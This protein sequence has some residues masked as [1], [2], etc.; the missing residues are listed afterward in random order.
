MDNHQKSE[1]LFEL[2]AVLGRQNEFNE[3]LRI[4]STKASALVD[5]DVATILMLNPHTQD[6]IKTIYKDG[7]ETND[8]HEKL[9]RTNVIGLMLRDKQPFFSTNLGKDQRF[10]KNLFKATTVKSVIAVPLLCEDTVFGCLLVM[11]KTSEFETSFY[12]IRK[13]YVSIFAPGYRHPRCEPN[14]KHSVYWGKANAF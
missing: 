7:H 14:M 3:I 9:V 13:K 12:G 10:R 8:K 5:A 6:T 11:H 4:V 1:S 2:A